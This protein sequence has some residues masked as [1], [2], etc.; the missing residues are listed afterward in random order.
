M[1]KKTL[2]PFFLLAG[3]ILQ[4]AGDTNALQ[5]QFEARLH[6]WR[7]RMQETV[8]CPAEELKLLEA[9]AGLMSTYTSWMT[10]EERGVN[11]ARVSLDALR[12]RSSVAGPVQTSLSAARQRAAE[13]LAS[14]QS[15]VDRLRPLAMQDD[16]TD[17]GAS[18]KRLDAEIQAEDADRKRRGSNIDALD[19]ATARLTWYAWWFH[20][21]AESAAVLED[22][23]TSRIARVQLSGNRDQAVQSLS[24]LVERWRTQQPGA[25][26]LRQITEWTVIEDATGR[27]LDPKKLA[28]EA[29]RALERKN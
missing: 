8:T 1:S 16:F 10:A 25:A 26:G 5:N 23:Y 4:A 24:N 20:Q 29:R 7:A 27:R 13:L 18:L 12:R 9:E 6:T 3:S 17:A 15:K 19:N 11:A 14:A 2:L 21:Q 22:V 28:K